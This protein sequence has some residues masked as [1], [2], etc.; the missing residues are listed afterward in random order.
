MISDQHEPSAN[1]PCTSTT[2]RAFTGG[3]VAAMPREDTSEAAA[4]A[5]K[6]VEKVRLFIIMIK[7]RME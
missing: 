2:L 3:V 6:A 5:S 4:P 1:R 7:A